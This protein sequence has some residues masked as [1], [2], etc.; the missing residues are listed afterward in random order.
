M[1][2][3]QLLHQSIQ[4]KTNIRSK[5]K[6]LCTLKTIEQLLIPSENYREKFLSLQFQYTIQNL[7]RAR[8]MDYSF[9]IK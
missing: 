9:A 8:T 6:L 2:L 1:L 7:Q 5:I 3:L 4:Y